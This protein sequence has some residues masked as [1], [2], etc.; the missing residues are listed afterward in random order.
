M[1]DPGAIVRALLR[2]LEESGWRRLEIVRSFNE[3]RAGGYCVD[4]QGRHFQVHDLMAYEGI[5]P[6]P[7]EDPLTVVARRH[8]DSPGPGAGPGDRVLGGLPAAG[9]IRL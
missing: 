9:R 7:D 3:S 1:E 6:L 2:L 8:L 4:G 5:A